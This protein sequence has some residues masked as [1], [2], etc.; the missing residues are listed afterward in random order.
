MPFQQQ[1]AH[2]VVQLHVL[3]VD[4]QHLQAACLIWHTNVN[5]PA[6]G[7]GQGQ[8]TQHKNQHCPCVHDCLL[9]QRKPAQ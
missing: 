5:L 4:A 1:K 7:Q 3:G 6:G 2:L 8:Q 9:T